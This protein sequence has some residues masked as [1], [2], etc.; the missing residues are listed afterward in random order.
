MQE[1]RKRIMEEI[2]GKLILPLTVPLLIYKH[3]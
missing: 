1:I 3:S 2:D